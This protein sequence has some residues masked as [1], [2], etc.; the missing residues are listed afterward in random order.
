MV[1]CYGGLFQS[2]RSKR[3]CPGEMPL[4]LLRL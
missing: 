3:H 1:Y 2:G 4:K